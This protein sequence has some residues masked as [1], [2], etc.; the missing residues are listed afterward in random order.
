MRAIEPPTRV[1]MTVNTDRKKVLQTDALMRMRAMRSVCCGVCDSKS[2]PDALARS[3]PDYRGAFQA[4]SNAF[5]AEERALE[6]LGGL[7]GSTSLQSG[8]YPHR[9][10]GDRASLE[11]PGVE[12]PDYPRLQLIHSAAPKGK[13]CGGMNRDQHSLNAIAVVM[14]RVIDF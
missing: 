11:P 14:E 1:M 13:G 7:T 9:G 2:S 4:A 10:Q 3:S 6:D 8:L 5:V 12:S